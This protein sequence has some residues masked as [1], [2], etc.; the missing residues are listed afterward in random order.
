MR[1][2]RNRTR[3]KVG[4]IVLVKDDDKFGYSKF[5]VITEIPSKQSLKIRVRSGDKTAFIVRPLS[6]TVPIVAQCLYV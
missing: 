6:I 5:G 1:S 4:D 3:K 2:S